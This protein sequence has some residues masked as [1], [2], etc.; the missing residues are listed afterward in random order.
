MTPQLLAEL[1]RL[2]LFPR[3]ARDLI[4]IAGME[5]AA[6]IITAWGGQVWPVP[7]VIGGGNPQ[8]ARR[9]GQLV[10]I[11][12]EPAATRIVRWCPGSELFVPNLKEVLWSRTQDMIRAD[13]DRLTMTGGYSVREAIFDLGLKYGCSGAAVQ[14]T[15]KRPDNVLGEAVAESPLQGA[16]F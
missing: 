6:Q 7:S 9:W 2:P 12:G 11:V 14:R 5:G 16:L 8:G 15:L 13:F 10:E 1:S 3:T 4:R